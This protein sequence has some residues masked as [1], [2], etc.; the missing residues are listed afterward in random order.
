MQEEAIRELLDE[1]LARLQEA[2]DPERAREAKRLFPREVRVLGTPSGWANELGRYLSSALR[3]QGGDVRDAL[4]LAQRLYQQQTMEAGTVANEMLGRWWRKL[5]VGDWERFD[6]WLDWFDNWGTT[7]SFCLKVSGPL[8]ARDGAPSDVLRRWARGDSVWR[9]RAAL[10]SLIP[11]ARKGGER[12]LLLELCEEL[13][14]DDEPYVQKAIGWSLKELCKGD[15]EA[16]IGFLQAH[17]DA[18]PTSTVRYAC[19]RMSEGER[20]SA[21]RGA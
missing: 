10:V 5:G 1:V 20:D 7:D 14:R 18:M 21:R 2:A 6:R 15:M 3:A 9:R 17:G 8:V 12:D 11:A 13:L 16:V 4:W 19:E